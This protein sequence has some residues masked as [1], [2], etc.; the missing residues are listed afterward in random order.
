MTDSHNFNI[1]FIIF[2]SGLRN[3]TDSS[4]GHLPSPASI[5]RMGRRNGKALVI[6]GSWM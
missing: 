6:A 3:H 4:P 1:C 2:E 5:R